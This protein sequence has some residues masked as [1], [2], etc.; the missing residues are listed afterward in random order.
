MAPV[1]HPGNRSANSR[2]HAS[3]TPLDA[4]SGRRIELE[5]STETE[6]DRERDFRMVKLRSMV[7][8]ADASGVN[9]TS[10]TDTRIT[11]VGRFIR[12][13]KLDELM[14]LWN[15]LIGDMSLVGPRPNVRSETDMYTPVERKLLTVRPG[16]T[17]LASIVFSD[18]GEIL[19]RSPS[20]CRAV[21]CY[22]ST[23]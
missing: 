14:Q 10:N 12:K 18:E 4:W 5:L 23:R 21:F 6:R 19:S 3:L 9:S 16:I 17:D 20:V 22:V 1:S 13:F 2:S 11:A 15:V 7:I 8:N